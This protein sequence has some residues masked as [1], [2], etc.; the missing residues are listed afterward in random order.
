MDKQLIDVL[1]IL[2]SCTF[3]NAEI[4]NKFKED[5]KLMTRVNEIFEYAKQNKNNRLEKAAEGLIWKVEKEE[6]FKQEH[7]AEAERKKQKAQENGVEAEE[8]EQY[9]LMISY[10][11]ADKEL[12]H[13]IFK[14]LTEKSGYKVWIDQEQMHG[15]TIGA[16]V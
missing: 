13:R 3:N 4:L 8:S 16:M 11:W 15:S 9:D 2:W 5:T 14:H 1:K 7:E 12:V 6:K 10:S